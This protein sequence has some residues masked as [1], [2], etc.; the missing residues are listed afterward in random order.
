MGSAEDNYQLEGTFQN[1][2]RLFDK[3]EE[4]MNE[5]SDLFHN[6]YGFIDSTFNYDV[7]VLGGQY[8]KEQVVLKW[9]CAFD[10]WS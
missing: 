4:F 5:A 7:S 9:S 2:S 8:E 3:N 10:R 1:A 6:A